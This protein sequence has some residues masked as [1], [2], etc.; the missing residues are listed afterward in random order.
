VTDEEE[1]HY[2]Q[3]KVEIHEERA[4]ERQVLADLNLAQAI[5]NAKA[6]KRGD[7]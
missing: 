2:R 3:R 4:R 6:L 5:R 7:A 1:K